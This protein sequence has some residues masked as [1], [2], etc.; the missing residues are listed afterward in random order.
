MHVPPLL[1]SFAALE[2]SVA[3]S[4]LELVNVPVLDLDVLTQEID[5]ESRAVLDPES[6][7]PSPS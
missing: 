4:L 5:D 1:D 7:S 6:P 3:A 2:K